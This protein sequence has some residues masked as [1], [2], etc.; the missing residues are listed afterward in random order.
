MVR[1][2]KRSKNR[3]KSRSARSENKKEMGERIEGE[4][5]EALPNTTFR[6]KLDNGR[7]VLAHLSGKMRLY[8][9]RIVS[10]DRVVVEFSPYDKDKGRIVLRK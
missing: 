1:P 9:I 10:G 7:I 8:R 3:G 6:V 4:V 2:F 5:E